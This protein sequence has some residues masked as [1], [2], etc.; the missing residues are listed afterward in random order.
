MKVH[1][2]SLWRLMPPLCLPSTPLASA[3]S[4]ELD[5]RSAGRLLSRV[6][7][8]PRCWLWC[9]RTALAAWQ[10]LRTCRAATQHDSGLKS[11][12]ACACA[13]HSGWAM[14]QVTR[15]LEGADKAVAATV[16][17]QVQHP[18]TCDSITGMR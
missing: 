2:P 12:T 6:A 11:L 15:M 10:M 8:R 16:N 1:S 7:A 18:V 9:C 17:C 14:P 3:S 4:T 5:A 13:D